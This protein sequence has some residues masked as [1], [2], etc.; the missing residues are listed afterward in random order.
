MFVY[1]CS[2]NSLPCLS[3]GSIEVKGRIGSAKRDRASDSGL[4]HVRSH[5]NKS[6]VFDHQQQVAILQ[7]AQTVGDHESSAA[8]HGAVHRFH[9][10][11]FS[12]HVD[13]TGR[14]VQD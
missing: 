4:T 5:L 7:R 8:M 6:S 3:G 1:L 14:L 10:R 9:N 13:G 11:G 12:P 2:D